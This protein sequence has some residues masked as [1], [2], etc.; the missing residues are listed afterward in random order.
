MADNKFSCSGGAA[1]RE[2]FGIE[3]GRIL[4]ACRDRDCFEDVRVY[5]TSCGQEL[6]ARTGSVRVKK[7]CISGANIVTQGIQF[8]SGFYS[9]DIKFYVNCT[10]EVCVPMGV[11]QEFDGIAVVEKRVVLYGGEAV[12]AMARDFEEMFP[13]CAEVTEKYQSGRSRALRIGQYILRLFAPLL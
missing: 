12:K 10:F 11:A 8:N 2:T 3:T 1:G 6:I 5:L 9:V 7:A 13:Q 4:D